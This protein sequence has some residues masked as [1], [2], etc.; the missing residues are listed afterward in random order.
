[1]TPHVTVQHRREL[2]REEILSRSLGAGEK[3]RGGKSFRV[4]AELRPHAN[5]APDPGCE[6][7]PAGPSSA[8]MR[9]PRGSSAIPA[10]EILREITLICPVR[11]VG[12]GQG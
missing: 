11:L 6:P 12:N 9:K 7:E 3:E 4:N 1:M 5:E 2:D 8:F 10:S